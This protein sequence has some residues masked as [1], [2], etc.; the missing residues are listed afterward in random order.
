MTSNDLYVEYFGFT[1]R[2]FT[3]LPDPD[4]LFWSRAHRRAF[5]VLEFGVITRA[6]ITV[7]T[8]EV[9]A[10]KT[11]L[12]Q[13]LLQALD[14]DITLGLISNAQGGRGELLQWVLNSLS[15]QAD[16]TG[17]Y[18]TMFQQLQDYV[19]EEYAS[20][21]RVVLVIDEAQNL[22]I[23]GLEELRMLT[24]IN[25]NKDELLQL[26][27]VGQPELRQMIMRPELRQFAQRVTATYHIGALDRTAVAG[28]IQHRLNHVG[29]SGNEF[30]SDAIDL[31]HEHSRGIPRLVNKLCDFAMVYAATEERRVVDGA[32]IEEVLEDGI[33]LPAVHVAGDAAE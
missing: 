20:G 22:S 27:L 13:K 3:L 26:I 14:D 6:P 12:I 1:E 33:F 4:F 7:V 15:I 30:T 21:R 5:S 17:S 31:I 11:T 16:L 24:N 19:I 28:Y 10:G 23:E 2:P 9:G 32:I 25:S 29:G 8:G 18:V